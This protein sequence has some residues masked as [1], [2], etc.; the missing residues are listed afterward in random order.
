VIEKIYREAKVMEEGVDLPASELDGVPT[1]AEISDHPMD[2]LLRTERL[3]HIWCPGCGLGTSLSCFA[4]ALIRS[5]LDLDQVS[6]VSGIGCTGRVAGYLRLDG[7]HTTHG[8]ALPFA[9]GLKLANDSLKVVVFSGDGDLIAIG[10]NHFIHAAR[11]NMDI[12]VICVNN[13]IYGMTGGQVGPTTPT[14]ASASTSPWGNLEHPFNVP[15]LAAAAG[16]TYVARWTALHA[17]RLEKSI[18]RALLKPGFT[19]VEVISPCPTAFGRANRE[20]YGRD[21][22]EFYHEN[23]VIRHGAHPEDVNIDLG[24]QI[25]CGEF[26]D[27]ERPTFQ[28]RLRALHREKAHAE[29]KPWAEL[30]L[31]DRLDP[32]RAIKYKTPLDVGPVQVR[33]DE[34]HKLPLE[35]RLGGFG[36]QGIILSGKIMGRAQAIYEE[37][38]VS[39]TRSYGPEA[40]GGACSSAL[41]ISDAPILYPH[42]TNPDLMVTMSQAAYTKYHG[43]LA[44]DGLLLVDADLVDL[45][46][47]ADQDVVRVPATHIAAED[48]GLR[49]V[50]NIVMLGAVTAVTDVTS[51]EA[52]R[53]AVLDS[54]PEGT[55]DLNEEAFDRGYKVGQELRKERNQE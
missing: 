20:A 29:Y 42:V 7:F 31:E 2:E 8:R 3:P 12:T 24:G 13:F 37:R 1:V 47:D 53:R 49:I 55:E 21:M 26:V 32:D 33:E 45:D 5:E 14:G 40:R 28:D 41:I 51:R 19:V 54:V 43:Q 38:Q 22:M 11:R 27:I 44:E 18:H 10:G 9:T 52:M 4:S 16:A 15:Y 46:P 35:V 30:D 34:G 25:I 6:I 50:A 39:L 48:L 36:G 17:R 23:A